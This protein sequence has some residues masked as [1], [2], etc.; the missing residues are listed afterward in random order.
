MNL[1]QFCLYLVISTVLFDVACAQSSLVEI[2]DPNELTVKFEF[3]GKAGET[4]KYHINLRD[5]PKAPAIPTGYA[6]LNKG[7]YVRTSAVPYSSPLL[8]FKVPINSE[9][10]FRKVRILKLAEFE[11]EPIGNRWVDCTITPEWWAEESKHRGAEA[12]EEAKA[13]ANL[14]S[15][16]LYPDFSQRSLRCEDR[17]FSQDNV[18][19]G[20]FVLVLE[21][22]APPIEA[23]TEI[24]VSFE[25]E[26][27]SAKPGETVYTISFRNVG[28]K[29]IAELNFR[30]DFASDSRV[31]FSQPSQGSCK[32]AIRGSLNGSSVCHLGSL[33]AG[34]MATVEFGRE[35]SG[36]PAD[37][38]AKKSNQSWRIEGGFKERPQDQFGEPNAFAF[39]PIQP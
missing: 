39:R 14:E 15:A 12:E 24:K 38:R 32:K 28:N 29:D 5:I 10:E 6:F 2:K 27:P 22:Q 13:K 11:M 37:S 36:M 34:K 21:T 26:K 17:S 25:S 18:P 33:A 20:Y 23:F 8:A 35:D 4:K 16:K 31:T 1:F 9:S 7:Y 30:S 3:L 19:S